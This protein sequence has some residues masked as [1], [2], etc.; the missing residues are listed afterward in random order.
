MS[1]IIKFIDQS[2]HLISGADLGFW[3]AGVNFD[4]FSCK[5]HVTSRKTHVMWYA[6]WGN[7]IEETYSSAILTT[8][9]EGTFVE[10]NYTT[11]KEKVIFFGI[12]FCEW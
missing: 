6:I 5:I 8:L 12:N 3:G 11:E 7:K 1:I 4:F 2:V 10:K 9:K